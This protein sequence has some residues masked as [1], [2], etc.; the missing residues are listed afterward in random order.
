MILVHNFVVQWNAN[1]LLV[2]AIDED[3]ADMLWNGES[4]LSSWSFVTQP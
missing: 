1:V 4:M 2:D 3:G